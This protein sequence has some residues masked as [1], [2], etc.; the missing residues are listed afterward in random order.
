MSRILPTLC[1]RPQRLYL[2]SLGGAWNLEN[3]HTLPGALRRLPLP[4]QTALRTSRHLWLLGGKSRGELLRH[5]QV[6]WYFGILVYFHLARA[7]GEGPGPRAGG[8]GPG[9][10]TKIPKYLNFSVPKPKILW[11]F[12]ISVFWTP[13]P[14]RATSPCGLGKI[15]VK[16][17]HERWHIDRSM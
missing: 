15:M 8:E 2:C 5:N 9:A 3:L 10:H 17:D 12:G 13:S 6:F 14:P 11:Y 7:G 1:L 16:S 4:L